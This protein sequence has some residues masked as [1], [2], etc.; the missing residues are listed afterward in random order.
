[1]WNLLIHHAT[2]ASN[3]L[4]VHTLA[5]LGCFAQDEK[6][7]DEIGCTNDDEQTV[8]SEWSPC[9]FSVP[10]LCDHSHQAWQHDSI[11]QSTESTNKTETQG[12]KYIG[13]T[14]LLYSIYIYIYIYMCNDNVCKLLE[15]VSEDVPLVEFMYLVFTH[16]PGE[17]YC[18]WLR[19]VV[20]LEWSLSSAN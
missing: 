13:H 16:M 11:G 18:R 6:L 17:S 12:K 15:D 2:T 1:M 9:K 5:E 19:S 8:N 7:W 10:V 14:L 3:H 4:A 20:M